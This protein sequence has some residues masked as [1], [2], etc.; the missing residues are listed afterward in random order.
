MAFL[1]RQ[2]LAFLKRS[3]AL[4]K[5]HQQVLVS[6]AVMGMIVLVRSAAAHAGTDTTFDDLNTMLEGWSKGSLGKSLALIALLLGVGV[7]AARQ[8][9]AALFAGVGVA[10]GASIGPTVVSTIITATF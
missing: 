6:L 4:F 9:F 7:A 2:S 5:R 3:M 8:S 1:K 10:A